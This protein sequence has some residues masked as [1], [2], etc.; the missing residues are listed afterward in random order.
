MIDY[1]VT[2]RKRGRK[3]YLALAGREIY[4]LTI[5]QCYSLEQI[6]MKVS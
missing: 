2:F 5:N 3:A 1:S 6:I 4:L